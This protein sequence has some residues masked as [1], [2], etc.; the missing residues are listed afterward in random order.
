MKISIKMVCIVFI[1]F[2]S[3][4][5]TDHSKQPLKPQTMK[6]KENIQIIESAIAELSYEEAVAK[7]GKTFS[8]EVFENAKTGE[9]F[10]GIRA[11]IAKYYL[12]GEK[13]TIREAIWHKTDSIDIAVWYTQKENK[14]MPFSHFEYNKNVDF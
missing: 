10:P 5:C 9:V 13:A 6:D 3:I 1:Y 4:C 8:T 7:Y 14:W 11:G 2:L 12:A